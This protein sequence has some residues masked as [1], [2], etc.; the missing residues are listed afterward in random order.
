MTVEPFLYL[1]EILLSLEKNEGNSN[2]Q[3]MQVMHIFDIIV[4]KLLFAG[5]NQKKNHMF[6][7]IDTVSSVTHVLHINL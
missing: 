3:K 5:T 6:C 4:F 2:S 7:S 1:F